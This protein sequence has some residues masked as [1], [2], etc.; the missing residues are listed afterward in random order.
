MATEKDKDTAETQ[1][2]GRNSDDEYYEV[3]KILK[4]EVREG[5]LCYLIRWVNY[6]PED[7]SW[8]PTSMLEQCTEI[9][10]AWE[11][12]KKEDKQK[13]KAEAGAARRG[14]AIAGR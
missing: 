14:I 11:E 9:I 6:P 4:E 3:E 10:A 7:D 8:E 2:G 13:N 12:Q 1:D 5:Q